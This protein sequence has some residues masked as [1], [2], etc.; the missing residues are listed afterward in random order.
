MTGRSGDELMGGGGGEVLK[1][2]YDTLD[3]GLELW[4]AWPKVTDKSTFR[5]YGVCVC[6][7]VCVCVRWQPNWS[8]VRHVGTVHTSMNK[9]VQT[10]MGN[11]SMEECAPDQ[12]TKSR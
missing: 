11:F 4:R 7:C 3:W 1:V 12:I 6:V 10:C 2:F 5:G 8:M 9:E